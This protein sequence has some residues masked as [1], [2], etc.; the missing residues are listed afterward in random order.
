MQEGDHEM[1]AVMVSRPELRSF[2]ENTRRIG[3]SLTGC[4]VVESADLVVETSD[5]PKP[6]RLRRAWLGPRLVVQ[7]ETSPMAA[8][9]PRGRPSRDRRRVFEG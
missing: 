6:R 9:E 1:A 2:G 3:E 8:A 4:D 7:D 5:P